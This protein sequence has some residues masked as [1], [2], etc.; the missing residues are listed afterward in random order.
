MP[1]RSQL[2]ILQLSAFL[3]YVLFEPDHA[4]GSEQWQTQGGD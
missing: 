1:T 3:S 2:H 4:V